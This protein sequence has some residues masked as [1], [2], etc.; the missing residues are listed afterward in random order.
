MSELGGDDALVMHVG[1]VVGG[2]PDDGRAH[3]EL[4]YDL[5]YV[6]LVGQAAHTLGEHFTWRGTATLA[7]VFGLIWIAWLNGALF[8][9]LHAAGRTATPGR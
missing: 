2:Q 6:V 7:V 9:E 3:L 8:Y 1:C 4:F 5:V